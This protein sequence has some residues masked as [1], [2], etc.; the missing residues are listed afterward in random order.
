M[1][2]NREFKV[3]DEVMTLWGEGIIF[4]ISMIDEYPIKVKTINGIKT[5]TLGGLTYEDH[6]IPTIFHR[7]NNPF[8]MAGKRQEYQQS[9]TDNFVKDFNTT[10]AKPKIDRAELLEVAKCYAKGGLEPAMAVK[11]AI[12]L[13]NEVNKVTDGE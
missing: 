7:D 11:G 5:F 10:T 2:K 9:V 4:D 13:L 12:E 6:E 3:G 8:E 1:W